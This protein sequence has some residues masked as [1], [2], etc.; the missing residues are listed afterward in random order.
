VA[1]RRGLRAA[2]DLVGQA[3]AASVRPEDQLVLV[4]PLDAIAP[5]A[6]APRLRVEDLEPGALPALAALG[7]RT[8]TTRANGRFAA[9]LARRYHGFIATEEGRPVGY[10][11]WHDRDAGPHPHLARLGIELGPGD[12]YGFDFFLAEDH[13]GEGR[14][15]EFLHAVETALRARGHERLWGYVAAGNTPARWLYAVR[16]YETVRTLHLRPG[17]MR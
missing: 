1:R 7:R 13:R 12:V 2:L 9:N 6:F 16:G 11:W 17:S 15:V 5:I 10:Y 14:A 8:C 4:K 3:L